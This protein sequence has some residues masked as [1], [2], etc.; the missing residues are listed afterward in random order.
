MFYTSPYCKASI[1]PQLVTEKFDMDRWWYVDAINTNDNHRFYNIFY[2][3]NISSCLLIVIF[4]SRI[5][6]PPW[7]RIQLG[8]KSVR[9]LIMRSNGAVYGKFITDDNV[10]D[11]FIGCPHDIRL[12]FIFTDYYNVVVLLGDDSSTGPHIMILRSNDTNMTYEQR[13]ALIEP[14]IKPFLNLTNITKV[15]IGDC[16]TMVSLTE[17]NATTFRKC[18]EFN[19]RRKRKIITKSI[20]LAIAGSGLLGIFLLIGCWFVN[21]KNKALVAPVQG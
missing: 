14:T 10:D 15:E 12:E 19:E 3:K 4:N 17:F 20:L 9:N 21:R 7:I 2:F 13:M 8:F 6:N 5:D 1:E 16:D 18:T 11:N